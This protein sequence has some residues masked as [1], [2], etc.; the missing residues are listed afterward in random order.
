MNTL[1][2]KALLI[3]TSFLVFV[4]AIGIY[5]LITLPTLVFPPMYIMSAG[6]ALSFGWIAG[7]FFALF[8]YLLQKLNMSM[9]QKQVL[10]YVAITISVLLAFE[11]IEIMHAWDDIWTSGPFLLF[12]LVAIVSGFISVSVSRNS[13]SDLLRP[14]PVNACENNKAVSPLNPDNI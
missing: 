11:G 3:K 5:L 14:G 4:R 13:I 12:P 7:L 2:Y 10:L 6:F 8:F 1:N 9:Q